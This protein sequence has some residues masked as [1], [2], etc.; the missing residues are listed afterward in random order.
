LRKKLFAAC[1]LVLVAGLAL[2]GWIYSRA[3][4]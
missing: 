4:E 1:A 2:A 3:D